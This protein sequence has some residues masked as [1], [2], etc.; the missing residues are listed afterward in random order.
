MHMSGGL[1]C[2]LRHTLQWFQWHLYSPKSTWS[3]LFLPLLHSCSQERAGPLTW[4]SSACVAYPLQ[5]EHCRRCTL[6]WDPV[7]ALVYTSL[8]DGEQNTAKG[9]ASLCLQSL[10]SYFC[11]QRPGLVNSCHSPQDSTEKS[12]SLLET[13]ML[14]EYITSQYTFLKLTMRQIHS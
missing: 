1:Q 3:F 10:P 8:S 5:M 11:R 6:V 2:D 7:A 14:T 9:A 13:G 4:V 12:R